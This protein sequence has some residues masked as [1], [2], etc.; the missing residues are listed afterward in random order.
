MKGAQ[1][2]AKLAVN[3]FLNLALLPV[4]LV[5]FTITT[6]LAVSQIF[7]ARVARHNLRNQKNAGT[8]LAVFGTSAVLAHYFITFIED[9]VFWPLGGL[10]IK[11]NPSV[12][13]EIMRASSY[14]ADSQRG[15]AI[16]SAH[17]GNIEVSADGLLLTAVRHVSQESPLIAL[18]KPSKNKW[19][20]KFLARYRS[21]RGIEIIQTN[22]KDL[23]RA[24]LQGFK[25]KRAIAL[26][27]D[28]KPA[29][30]GLFVNFFGKPAAF[31]EGGV[32][33][34]IKSQAEIVCFASR[35]VFP[36]FYS[37]EGRWLR[38]ETRGSEPVKGIIN[39]YAAWLES[40][41]QKSPWQWCWDYKKWSR[42]PLSDG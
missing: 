29:R 36:G 33:I 34:A 16:L 9:F 8:L 4:Y 32:E 18:A 17:F 10:I 25:Q 21:A 24:M 22:R 6:L 23:V 14:A 26:L 20:T 40:I 35:R 37:Y 28:Q 41:I 7:P 39:S 2:K 12:Q 11:H 15:L 42:L 3:L 38:D 19:A 1:E 5:V 27:V 13:T 31:P 30:A